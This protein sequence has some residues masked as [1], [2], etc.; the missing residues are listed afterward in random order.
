MHKLCKIAQMLKQW[1][2][3][4]K[5][6]ICAQLCAQNYFLVT[7]FRFFSHFF[8]WKMTKNDDFCEKSGFCT[9]ILAKKRRFLGFLQIAPIKQCIIKF[10]IFENWVQKN[11]KNGG[12][13][14]RF[15]QNFEKWPTE[16]MAIFRVK[17]SLSLRSI[18][19]RQNSSTNKVKTPISKK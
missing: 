4:I 15:W 10:Q 3:H 7:G 9:E 19:K 1:V 16:K 17:F 14:E 5:C 13:V 11:V 12:W 2:L 6:T 18:K 8:T